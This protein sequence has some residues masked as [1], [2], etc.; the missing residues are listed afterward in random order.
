MSAEGERRESSITE[1]VVSGK[2]CLA[3]RKLVRIPSKAVRNGR[4]HT[5]KFWRRTEC[6]R[7]SVS[8]YAAEQ[9]ALR[10][11]DMTELIAQLRRVIVV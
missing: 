4:Q 11:Y 5:H 9:H 8:E 10:C 7:D 6:H 3:G 2:Y 1:R